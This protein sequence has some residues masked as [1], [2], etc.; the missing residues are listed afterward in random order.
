[1]NFPKNLDEWTFDVIKEFVDKGYDE[2]EFFDMKDGLSNPNI[3]QKSVSAFANTDGG[4]LIY[5]VRDKK[6]TTDKIIGVDKNKDFAKEFYDKIKNIAPSIYFTFKQSPILI[7]NTDKIIHVCYIP[8]SHDRP[9]MTQDLKFYKRTQ[10]GSCEQ[11]SYHELR[12]SFYG[13]EQRKLKITMLGMELDYLFTTFKE[14]REKTSEYNSLQKAYT[15]DLRTFNELLGQAFVVLQDKSNLLTKL[16]EIRRHVEL[17]NQVAENYKSFLSRATP[18][19][20]EESKFRITISDIG[21]K[22]HNAII[23]TLK[24]MKDE[25]GYASTHP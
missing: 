13:L 16:F 22:I 18:N 2:T 14:L 8:K 12:D 21:I 23:R 4:Y 24:L 9:H 15:V 19:S 6:L 17:L 10:G 7:P 25:L 5:E 3:T 1:M 20:G 11:M